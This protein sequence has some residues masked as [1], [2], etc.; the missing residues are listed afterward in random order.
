MA[1]FLD[2]S[3]LPVLIEQGAQDGALAPELLRGARD[4]RP[5]P[6]DRN[7]RLVA[8]PRERAQSLAAAVRAAHIHGS[9]LV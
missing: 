7:P 4:L 8:N 9:P 3:D 1:L 5:R 2:V 6:N